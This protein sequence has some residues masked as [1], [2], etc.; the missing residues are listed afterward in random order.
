MRHSPVVV[1]KQ[2]YPLNQQT[3][4]QDVRVRRSLKHA[5]NWVNQVVS[6]LEQNGGVSFRDRQGHLILVTKSAKHSGYWQATWFK[7]EGPYQDQLSHT[8]KKLI[9][10][11][12]PMICEWLTP[13]GFER[14]VNRWL[15]LKPHPL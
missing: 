8:A 3:T 6:Q 15:R 12:A 11:L 9:L 1:Q 7:P 10:N 4:P 5:A 14:Q 13:S 2:Q